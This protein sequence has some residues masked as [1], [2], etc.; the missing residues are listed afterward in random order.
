MATSK[1]KLKPSPSVKP[2]PFNADIEGFGWERDFEDVFNHKTGHDTRS[3]DSVTFYYG[4]VPVGYDESGEW[5]CLTI[6]NVTDEQADFIKD[7]L[8]KAIGVK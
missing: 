8:N 2:N 4:C 6:C 5:N 1:K 3:L 7:A